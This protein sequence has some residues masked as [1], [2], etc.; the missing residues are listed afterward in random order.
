MNFIKGK[1]KMPEN[2]ARKSPVTRR[3][4]FWLSLVGVAGV[5]LQS[6]EATAH[7]NPPRTGPQLANLKTVGPQGQVKGISHRGDS[8]DVTTADGR[9]TAFPETNLRFKVDTSDQG[10]LSG[11]PVILPSG[12]MGDRAVVFFASPADIG[13]IVEYQ[14]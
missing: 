14:S 3:A 11:R 10:P 6:R 8:F 5:G 2:S 13:R 1:R 12:M 4:A 9:T 7:V